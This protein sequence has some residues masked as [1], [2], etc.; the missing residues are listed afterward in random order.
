MSV[1]RQHGPAATCRRTACADRPTHVGGVH[2]D[3]RHPLYDGPDISI[4][5]LPSR[6]RTAA[7]TLLTAGAP[8]PEVIDLVN[9]IHGLRE[10]AGHL[11]VDKDRAVREAMRRADDCET[12]GADLIALGK[13][14][15]HFDEQARRNDASRVAVLSALWQFRDVVN[16]LRTRER[17]GDVLPSSAELVE[18]FG[19]ALDKV[20]ASHDRAWRK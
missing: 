1:P 6:P 4:R 15:H 19:K 9:E 3:A 17:A 18:M 8:V 2:I 5:A 12:H 13:Q 16:A 20:S 10:Q 11:M 7:R 14:A